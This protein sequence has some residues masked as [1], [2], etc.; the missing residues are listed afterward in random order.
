MNFERF[1]RIR[2]ELRASRPELVDRAELDL[3]RSLAQFDPHSFGAIAPSPDPRAQYRCHVAEQFLARIGL[4][5]EL[6]PRVQVSHGVRRSLSVLFELLAARGATVGI[7]DDVYP[8]YGQLA[9]EAGVE[10]ASWPARTGLPD[11]RLLAAV[12]ALLICEPL[13]PWGRTLHGDDLERL[14]AWANGDPQ[15]MLIL[16]S[17]YAIPP[18]SGALSLLQDESAI[19][20][21]SLSKGWLI[22]DHVGLCIVPTRWQQA[23]REAFSGLPKHEL[24]LRIGFAA[25]TDHGGRPRQV[26]ATLARLGQQLDEQTQARPELA[27]SACVGYFAISELSFATLLEH[28]ILGV[29]ASVFGGDP[30]TPGC[31]LSS[32]PVVL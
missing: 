27:T 3:Y 20:L 25:L 16:D 5:E 29:P 31:V 13:K 15:R 24:R 21:V 4:G 19:V 2:A 32:L 23:A 12:S 26:A 6:G 30:D 18:S 1:L 14:R 9:A 8:V 11:E 22:P 10:V 28:G 7:P 17:A